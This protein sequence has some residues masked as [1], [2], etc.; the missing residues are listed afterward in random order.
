MGM[1]ESDGH[2]GSPWAEVELEV[3]EGT[4]KDNIKDNFRQLFVH[5]T[6]TTTSQRA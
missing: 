6:T 4:S 5:N 1:R 2:L 3:A